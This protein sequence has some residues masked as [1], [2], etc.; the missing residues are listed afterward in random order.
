MKYLVHQVLVAYKEGTPS[1][2]IDEAA[3]LVESF[4][5][6]IEDVISAK[7][8]RNVIQGPRNVDVSFTTTFETIEALDAFKVHPEHKKL[9]EFDKPQIQNIAVIDY[10]TE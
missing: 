3:K 10:W 6:T 1:S 4:S 7:V 5:E 9:A 2:H 8:T